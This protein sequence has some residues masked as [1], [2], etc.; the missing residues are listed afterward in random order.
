MKRVKRKQRQEYELDHKYAKFVIIFL[1][2]G[3]T[4]V[5]LF[6]ADNVWLKAVLFIFLIKEFLYYYGVNVIAYMIEILA[7]HRHKHKLF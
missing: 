3:L 6:L 5:A 2:I 4:T 7:H 1:Q